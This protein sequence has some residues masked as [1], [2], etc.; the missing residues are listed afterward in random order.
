MLKLELEC[1]ELY[2][3]IEPLVRDICSKCMGLYEDGLPC[4]LHVLELLSAYY[5]AD[6]V[7]LDAHSAA[8][9]IAGFFLK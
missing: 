2:I 3:I 7:A 6:L 5:A 4:K 9:K 1:C 8:I